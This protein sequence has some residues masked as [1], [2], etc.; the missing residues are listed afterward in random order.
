MAKIDLNLILK[1]ASLSNMNLYVKD[2]ASLTG[3]FVYKML[4]I[5]HETDNI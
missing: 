4:I 2:G 3:I 5:N 1:D